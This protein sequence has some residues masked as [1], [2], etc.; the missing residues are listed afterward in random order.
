MGESEMI[1]VNEQI[2]KCRAQIMGLAAIGVLFVHSIEFV[3][4]HP[5]LRKI[6]EFGGTGVYIFVFLSAV[7]LYN[8]LKTRG[9]GTASQNSTK[10]DSLD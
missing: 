6:F 4:W 8:S 10:E 3:D 5:L 7:G 1:M 2:E 9:G